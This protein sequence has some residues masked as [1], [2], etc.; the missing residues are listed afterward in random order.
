VARF[1]DGPNAFRQES[2]V[3]VVLIDVFLLAEKPLKGFGDLP[4]SVAVAGQFDTPQTCP[5]IVE[6]IMNQ[7]SSLAYVT[8]IQTSEHK[9]AVSRMVPHHVEGL[10]AGQPLDHGVPLT[11]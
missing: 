9:N 7:S 11:R 1:G 8:K 2:L 5:P 3:K 4:A 10:V 6:M